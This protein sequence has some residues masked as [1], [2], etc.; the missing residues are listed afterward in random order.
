MLEDLLDQRAEFWRARQVRA[1]AGEIDPGEHHLAI[2]VFDQ[3]SPM[4]ANVSG[5]VCAAQPVTTIRA[6][7]RSRRSF[8]TACRACR[9]ASAVTAQVLTTTESASPA[10]CA[11]R[12]ITS[13]S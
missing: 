12:R 9:T 10:A 4:R 7:G 13:D 11:S 3:P 2:A 1:V 6:P 5:S 8:R